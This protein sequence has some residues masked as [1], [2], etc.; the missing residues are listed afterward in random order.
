MAYPLAY[1]T[2]ALVR[3]ALLAPGTRG[4]YPHPFPD[5]AR[6]GYAAVAL[7]AAVLGLAVHALGLALV[8]ADRFRRAS[9]LAVHPAREN[10]ISSPAGGP[11]K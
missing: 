10:R 5:A 3:G 2:F 4:R 1:V 6:Y 7:N 9:P 11:L 8:A